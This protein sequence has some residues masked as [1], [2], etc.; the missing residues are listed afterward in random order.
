V[1]AEVRK[2]YG[3]ANVKPGLLRRTTCAVPGHGTRCYGRPAERRIA[4]AFEYAAI[5]GDVSA[6]VD[7]AMSARELGLRLREGRSA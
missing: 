6:R 2:V 5:L 1:G 3:R 4:L 7:A